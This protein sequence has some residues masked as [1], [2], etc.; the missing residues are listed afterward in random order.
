MTHFVIREEMMSGGLQLKGCELL[1]FAVIWSYSAKGKPMYMSEEKLAEMMMYSREFVGR[2]LRALREK[3]LILRKGKHHG[4]QTYEYVVNTD[5]VRKKVPSWSE[6]TSQPGVMFSPGLARNDVTSGREI[7]SHYI[8]SDKEQ[9]P[10]GGKSSLPFENVELNRR[11]VAMLGSMKWRGRTQESLQAAIRKLRQFPVE[12]ALQ[13]INHTIE[14][15]YALVFDP[16]QE[17]FRRAN[18]QAVMAELKQAKPDTEVDDKLFAAVFDLIPENLRENAIGQKQG[19]RALSF[20]G[21]AEK[22]H[23]HC[24]SSLCDW[25]STSVKDVED[26]IIEIFP[27]AKISFDFFRT[28]PAGS[29][30]EHSSEGLPPP[31]WEGKTTRDISAGVIPSP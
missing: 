26:K 13:M 8:E 1:I 10:E 21:D 27:D 7:S 24:P 11:W 20:R 3:N 2:S 4:G 12:V 6:H 31:S 9:D 29:P 28:A 30:G 22:I 16:T 14:G 17:M 15:D 25:F 19:R 18:R 23:V 5:E